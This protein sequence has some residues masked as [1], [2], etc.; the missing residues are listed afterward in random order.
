MKILWLDD[1]PSTIEY[2]IENILEKNPNTQ[3]EVFERID[4]FLEFLEENEIDEKDTIFIID[5]M[6]IDEDKIVFKDVD[7]TIPEDLMAGV[8]LYKECLKKY[9]PNVFTILY[10]SRGGEDEEVFDEFKE[11]DKRLNKTLFII[12]KEEMETKFKEVLLKKGIK[13]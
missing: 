3:I 2:E 1:N 8:H 12:G 6:L 11:E 7:V 13:L 9:Y 5:I 10:T 4:E